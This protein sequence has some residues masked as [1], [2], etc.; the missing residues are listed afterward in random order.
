MA[1]R[2]LDD[3]LEWLRIPSISTGGGLPADLRRAAEWVCE[4]VE[5]AG[6]TAAVLETQGNPIAYGE[7]RA[8]R[9]DAPTVLVYGHYDVQGPGPADAWRSPPFE[10]EIREGRVYARGAA[11]DKGNFLPLLHAACNLARSG[12]LPVHVRVLV[13]GEEEVGSASVTDWLRADDRGADA[14]VVFDSAM[15]AP[16]TPAVVVGLRGVVVSHV[17]VR[18]AER[19]LHSGLFGGSAANALHVLHGMLG[20]L[21]PGPDGRL[22]DEL[23][24]GVAAPSPEELDSWRRLPPGEEVIGQAG[25]RPADADAAAE[26]YERTGADAS[27][28]VNHVTGGEPRTVVPAA[29]QATVSLR[30][31]PNQRSAEMAAVVERLLRDAAPAGVEVEMSG[32]RADPAL[33]PV[34]SRVM[35]IAAAAIERAAGAP[36]VFVRSGGSIP[37]VAGFAAAN[38]P[39][40]LSGFSLPEDEIHAPNESYRVESLRIGERAGHELLLGLGALR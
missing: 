17:R 23:R 5:A 22:R 38:I 35:R 16:D 36:P 18:V 3:L 26:F 19:D 20:E 13:E 28:D 29:A 30:L 39:T 11:D 2:L 25:G 21:L 9:A 8:G 12:E 1:D 10:P 33:F 27:L 34:D 14:A 4:R 6:G 7:L 15:V 24:Q 40:V 37:I 31:A 32:H